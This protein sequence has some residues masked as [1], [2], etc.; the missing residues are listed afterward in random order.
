MGRASLTIAIGGEYSGASAM[1]K[2][3]QDMKA[4]RE[5][6]RHAGGGASD[7]MKIGDSLVDIG[8]AM[9]V[10]GQRIES[11]GTGLTKLTAPIAAVGAVSVKLASD[12]ENSVAKVY[13][14]M[15][16]GV[17]STK[18]MSRSIL[19]L[20][21]E[22]GK[23]AT[24]L[25]DATYQAL[26][27]SVATDKAAGFVA[28]AVNLAKVGFTDT[29]SAVDVLT[30]TINA[31]GYSAEDAEMITGRLVQTQNKGKTTVNELASSLG[32]V[33]PT[34]SAYNVSLDNLCSSYVIM[35]KQGINTA[36]ATTMINGMLTELASEGSTVANILKEETGQSFGQLMES[37]MTLGEVIQLLSDHVD[38]N[39]EAFA[40]LWGNVRASKGALAIANAGAGEFTQAM[41]DM[42][43]SAG[44]VESALEDLETPSVKAERAI[45]A[46]KNTAIDLGEEIIGAAMPSIE[47]LAARAQGLYNWFKELDDGTKQLIVKVGSLAVAAGPVITVFGKLYGGVGTLLTGIGKSLQSIGTFTAAMKAAELEMKAAGATSVTLGA[48][49]TGAAASTGLLTK[50]T[51]LL[52]GSLAMIGIA[53]AV[54]VVSLIISAYNEWKQHTEMVEK[55]T[56][57]LEKAV[58]ASKQAYEGYVP[59]VDGA[60]KSTADYAKTAE[61][62]LKAQ[63]ELA[64]KQREAWAE[65]GTNAAVVDS[66]AQ[67]IAELTEKESLNETEQAKLKAAVEGFNEATGE[68][69]GITN[70]QTGELNVQ[71]EAILE[72]AEAYKEEARAQALREMYGDVVRQQI[73]DELALKRAKAELAAAQED[74]NAVSSLGL[75]YQQ[76]EI[77]AVAAAQAKVNELEA[78]YDST[79]A[80][81]ETY[82]EMM[83]E[84][85]PTFDDFN[86]ALDACGISLSDFG[87]IGEEELSRLEQS[88]DGSLNSIVETCA[89]D[90]VR[91]PDSLASAIKQNSGL[92]EDA[93]QAMF[94]AMVLQMTNGDVKA[95]AELLGHDIDAGLKAGIEGG[96]SIPAAAAGLMS[97]ETIDAAKAAFESSSPSQVMF[98]LGQD[99]DAGLSNGIDSAADKPKAAMTGVSKAVQDAVKGLPDYAKGIGSSSGQGM[100]Q[101]IGVKS[102]I[103]GAA[104]LS[105]AASASSGISG[106]PSAFSGTGKSA[107]SGFVSAIGSASAYSQGQGLASSGR[108]GLESVSAYGAGSSFAHGFA[109]GM[110]GVNVW[111]AAYNIGL[112]ALSAIKSALGIASPSKEAAKVGEWFGEGAVIGMRRTEASIAAES[113]RLSDIM[114]LQPTQYGTFAV[115]GPTSA[116]AAWGGPQSGDAKA[117]TIVYNIGDVNLDVSDLSGIASLEDF[118]SLVIRAKNANRVKAR[119]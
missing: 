9:Q 77:D 66:Y 98:R 55:A 6:A 14:I 96:S 44:L 83:A 113:R 51:N 54:A 116:G 57:G 23:S 41:N 38:G 35:T 27:A 15:D 72:V 68:S 25:A 85:V 95:A 62:C 74:L 34:A 92:P 60:A 8:S 56:T 12:Y 20:S 112:S 48:K 58:E 46:M 107:A 18:E 16:K 33:I 5:A 69:V 63:S 97:Q 93:Q 91:I 104:A 78:A 50:A 47:K 13:T 45:N 64:D 118:V 21:T 81:L 90:G 70:L 109:N 42:A 105:L 102:G 31:Y 111:S 99:V 75:E 28:D 10:T 115:P 103:V 4:M 30:T 80:T 82:L 19:D 101:S 110:G 87:D 11:F 119:R 22:T 106:S 36:N 117:T 114:T 71:R 37:G 52:K 65:Y 53:A 1:K 84:G 88:F 86:G 59:S 2:A 43:D 89:S 76:N 73:E 7:L 17:M 3:A 79:N 26:S 49:M 32:Q 108:R 67:T 61:E 29:A 39:S 94:D 24:E 40:N 100:A